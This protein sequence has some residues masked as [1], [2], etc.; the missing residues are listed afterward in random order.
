MPDVTAILLN[1]RRPLNMQRI[2]P[3]LRAQTAAP[4]I[5]LV[6]NGAEYDAEEQPDELWRIPEHV[7]PFARFLAAYAYDGWLYFQ[8][9]DV[10]PKDDAFIT[11]LLALAQERPRYITGVWGRHVKR[12][13]PH[14][15]HPDSYGPTNMVKTICCVLHRDTLSRIRF[16][17][18]Q[19]RIDDLWVGLETSGGK[20]LHYTDLAFA[21]RLEL[22][23]QAG[24]GMSQE[25]GHYPER[26][27]FCA[28]YLE[29]HLC[30][31]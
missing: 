17:P 25:P 13:P 10:L 30:R 15:Q 9:D 7:G 5:V 26:E 6:N 29:T 20:P 11:D 31:G 23:P 12:T 14:Y 19:R 24:V 2:I 8:D 27:A 3:T 22:L 4:R 28:W 1:Y 21:E 18:N 16:A